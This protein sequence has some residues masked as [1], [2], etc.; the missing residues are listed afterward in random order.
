VAKIARKV[1]YVEYDPNNSGG[2]WWMKDEDWHALERAGWKVQWATHGFVY[3]KSGK[4]VRSRDGTPKLAPLSKLPKS[5]WQVRSGEKGGRYMGALARHAFKAGVTLE[6]A[7][8]EFNRVTSCNATDAGCPCC[9]VPHRFTEYG[10]K[11]EY[12]RSGP[13]T[14]YSDRF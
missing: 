1:A 6:Q 2:S 5:D 7:V 3:D 11:G 9:G 4:N 12:L 8:E 14:S 10:P 13:N